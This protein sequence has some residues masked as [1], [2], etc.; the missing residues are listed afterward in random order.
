MD[1]AANG[2]EGGSIDIVSLRSRRF[3]TYTH[4]YTQRDLVLYALGLG[5]SAGWQ[6]V[7]KDA[8]A[9]IEELYL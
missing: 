8:Q 6:S 4:D 1:V 5:C 7:H 3:A 9:H 2:G